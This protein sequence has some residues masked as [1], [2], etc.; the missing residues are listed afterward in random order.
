MTSAYDFTFQALTSGQAM[1]LFAFKGKVIL[2]VNTASKC[3]FTWQYSGL[4]SLYKTY[5]DRGL[6]VIGVPCDDFGHQEP[7]EHDVIAEF[8]QVN[9]GV[10]FP[11]MQKEHVRGKEAHPFYQWAYETLGFGTG[12]KWNFHKYLID[13]N[14][15]LVD[16]FN[17][18]TKPDSSKI[19]QAIEKL[20]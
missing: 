5:Q 17:T 13:R 10:T 18:P 16:H 2:I 3:G 19:T 1:P 9:Y 14:G 11:M 4:E 12:P 7:A 6:V 8:C 15:N 20:L